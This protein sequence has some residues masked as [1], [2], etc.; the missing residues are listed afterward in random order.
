MCNIEKINTTK[1]YVIIR[2]ATFKF[3]TSD[4]NGFVAYD[5]EGDKAFYY[6]IKQD[7]MK[8]PIEFLLECLMKGG[9]S[10]RKMMTKAYLEKKTVRIEQLEIEWAE[11]ETLFSTFGFYRP[12]TNAKIL[13]MK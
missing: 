11:Y 2:P 12:K 5:N 4:S 10:F 6:P 3:R 7:Y 9:I 1:N 8:D 13:E